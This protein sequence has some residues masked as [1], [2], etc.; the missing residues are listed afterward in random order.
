MLR[1]LCL[2]IAAIQP[3]TISSLSTT[4]TP[5]NIVVSLQDPHPPQTPSTLMKTLA[6]DCNFL[7][8]ETID[9]YGDY[10]STVGTSYLRTFEAEVAGSLGKEDAVFMPSGVMAQSIALLIHHNSEVVEGRRF[11]CHH[12]SHLLLHEEEG[13]R[14]L[15]SMEPLVIS[16]KSDTTDEEDNDDD[17][18]GV[19][20]L[21][22]SDVK[23]AFISKGGGEE[24]RNTT[25]LST[26]ILELPHRELGG[27]L[28]P[29]ED[30]Q[31]MKT[32]CGKRGVKF[33]CDG[34]RLF[35]ASAGYGLPLTELCDPFDS[36][37][38]SFYK[39]LGGIA[40]A[41]LVGDAKFCAEARLWLRRFG[42]NLYTLLPYA[43]GGWA[44]YRQCITKDDDHHPPMTF[45]NR[46]DKMRRVVSTLS[47]RTEP[48]CQ[49][50]SFDPNLP[51]TNMVH[52]YIRA[53]V[54]ECF[55]ARDVV[56]REEGIRVF[57]RVREIEKDDAAYRLG[58]R[59]KFEYS[60]GDYNGSIDDSTYLRGWN[61]FASILLKSR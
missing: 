31:K 42:G 32:L 57:N 26:F 27:K 44:G 60:I 20:P 40:G 54:E 50:V 12:S 24:G 37:Y 48:V 1:R 8:I 9:V 58:Y 21:T 28:T 7:G 52:G 33:H 36:V 16:T 61:E 13:F 29:W 11:A 25:G 56:E 22:Y 19:S 35:E 10:D 14:H 15:L 34:A 47:C 38:I 5:P 17:E 41:M 46:R 51:Q 39:G 18:I 4:T 3:T 53:S 59:S 43:I 45:V 30:V 23:R 6:N 55:E 2:L 49:V